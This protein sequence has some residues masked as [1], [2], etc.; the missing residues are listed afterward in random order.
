MEIIE[1]NQW[2]LECQN[3]KHHLIRGEEIKFLI[4]EGDSGNGNKLTC[5]NCRICK[6]WKAITKQNKVWCRDCLPPYDEIWQVNTISKRDNNSDEE[7]EEAI[8]K[9]HKS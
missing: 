5:D 9:M 2:P 8:K 6:A 4:R 3:Q 1:I 7:I